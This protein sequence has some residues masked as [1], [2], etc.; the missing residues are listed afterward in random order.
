MWH[1]PLRQVHAYEAIIRPQYPNLPKGTRREGVS[2]RHIYN[3]W[4]LVARLT[5][6]ASKGLT[7]LQQCMHFCCHTFQPMQK[8]HVAPCSDFAL[9][10]P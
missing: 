3:L 4:G 1:T 8:G 7:I 9:F 6:L 2:E 5:H 10:L